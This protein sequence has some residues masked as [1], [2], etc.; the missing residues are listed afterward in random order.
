MTLTWEMGMEGDRDLLQRAFGMTPDCPHLPDL[1]MILERGDVAAREH[2][3]SCPH[4]ASEVQLYNQFMSPSLTREEDAAVAWVQRTLK[5]PAEAEGPW[6]KISSWLSSK[7]LLPLG[8]AAA[9]VV[10]AIGVSQTGVSVSPLS[11]I[12]DTAQRSAAM[13]LLAPKGAVDA[14]PDA[15]RWNA[16]R[17]AASYRVKL[18]EVDKTVVW[19]STAASSSL[20]LPP[21]VRQK[22]LPGKRLIWT[23]DAVDAAG[24]LIASGSQDFRQQIR[25]SE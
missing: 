21:A 5:N 14:A 7:T 25:H 16:V 9:A 18:M 10:V 19:E 2:A 17:G 4:C 12:V 13:E 6:W 20:I 11:P 24:K 8:V 15:F 1:V 3:A 23:V 22:A